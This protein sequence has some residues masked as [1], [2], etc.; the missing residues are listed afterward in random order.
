MIFMV[1]FDALISFREML[2]ARLMRVFDEPFSSLAAALLLGVR[3]DIPYDIKEAFRQTGLTHVLALSGFNISILIN[4]IA[5]M[6]GFLPRRLRGVVTIGIITLFTIMVGAQASIVR[7]A[8]MGSISVLAEIIGRPYDSKRALFVSAAVM[9]IIEPS[10]LTDIGFQLSFAATA[11]IIFHAKKCEKW[12]VFLPEKFGLRG[13]FSTTMAAYVWTLPVIMWHF[14]GIS[15]ISPL[16]NL[17]V[18]PMIPYLML[19][20]F[21]SLIFGFLTALPTMLL[22]KLMLF[23]IMGTAQTGVGYV[24]I[25]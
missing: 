10:I 25:Q 5:R 24:I 3:S 21:C 17:V 18:L 19:G 8:I 11:G 20:S 14:D 4:S 7:A 16:V 6:C 13:N 15:L 22:F 9:V 2:V 12:M 1:I 23:V